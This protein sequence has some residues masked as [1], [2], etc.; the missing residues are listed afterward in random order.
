M[1][2][3]RVLTTLAAADDELSARALRRHQA[4]REAVDA[5]AGA[6]AERS[7]RRAWERGRDEALRA[8]DVVAAAA[9]AG[10]LD[11][12][13]SRAAELVSSPPR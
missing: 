1:T 11:R 8:L 12:N 7:L 6:K 2:E 9:D 10:V 5:R 4:W 3:E 13:D